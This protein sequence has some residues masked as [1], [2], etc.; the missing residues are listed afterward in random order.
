M[1]DAVLRTVFRLSVPVER[2]AYAFS[3]KRLGDRAAKIEVVPH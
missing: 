2:I 3:G 1:T